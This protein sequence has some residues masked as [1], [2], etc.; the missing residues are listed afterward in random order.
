MP[1]L[2]S[3][4][5]VSLPPSEPRSALRPRV[6]VA[7]GAV[8]SGLMLALL[9]VLFSFIPARAALVNGAL[10]APET[11]APAMA[12]EMAAPAE[13]EA[14]AEELTGER[15]DV[16]F[17]R[18][19]RSP[20]SGGLLAIPSTFT[21][22]DGAYDLVIHFHG[23]AHLV[24]ESFTHAG[25]NAVVAA[26][27]LGVGSGGYEEQ[28]GVPWG[29]PQILEQTQA[30]LEKR[31]LRGAKL[32]RL[33]L[34]AFSAGYA[35]VRRILDQPALA[36]HV[37]AVL[38]L[39]GIHVNYMP[40]DHSMNLERIA[41]FER[42]ARQAA[43]GKKLFFIS[44]SEITPK[45]DYASTH[46]TTDKLLELV[47]ATRLLGGESPAIPEL[48]WLRGRPMQRLVP[49]SRADEGELHVRGYA[50]EQK[51]DHMMHLLQ[52][53]VTAAPELVRYW[54]RSAER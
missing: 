10:S 52:M 6:R 49:L 36:D 1:E 18:A 47:G 19:R 42:F 20:I 45:G 48:V 41:S 35:A 4:L 37:D 51:D 11:I 53:S 26:V 12:L 29:L 15:A 54:S 14:S 9:A 31:G 8:A 28:F 17:S 32:R 46:E 40:R 30:A 43:L 5:P 44:H 25:L 23:E 33:A 16:T 2:G 13:P 24:E 21:S 3:F 7:L 34:S 27:N 50:G 22:T 38:L 39:D